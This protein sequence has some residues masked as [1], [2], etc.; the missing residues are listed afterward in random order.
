VKG[1]RGERETIAAAIAAIT[2]IGLGTLGYQ[3]YQAAAPCCGGLSIELSSPV[4]LDPAVR[5]GRLS[6]GMRYFVRANGFP[7]KRAELRLV[8][9]AG[10]VLEDESQRG[11]AHAVEHMAFRGTRNFPKHRITDYLESIGMRSG[12]DVNAQTTFDETTYRLAVPTDRAGALDTGIAILREWAQE[13]TFDPAEAKQEAGVVF[14]EW[15][16]RSVPSDRLAWARDTI[17][18]SGSPYVTRRPIGDTSVLRRFDVAEMRRFYR[19]WYRPDLMAVVAVGDFN[20]ASMESLIRKRFGDLPRGA[21]SAQR[22]KASFPRAA[23]RVAVLRDPEIRATRVAVWYPRQHSAASTVGEYRTALSETLM[24]EVLE[25]RLSS[26][27]DALD[28]PLLHAGI[29]ARGIARGLEAQVV[30]GSVIHGRVADGIAMIAEQVA[31]VQRFGV[32]DAELE[33]AKESVMVSRRGADANG[34]NSADITESLIWHFLH[35]HPFLAADRDYDLTKELLENITVDDVIGAAKRL[36]LDSASIIVTTPSGYRDT[37]LAGAV[38]QSLAG[39][40]RFGADR[41]ARKPVDSATTPK[42]IQRRPAD[43]SIAREDIHRDL[44]VYEWTLG[45]GMRVIVK[46]TEFNPGQLVLRLTEPG[47]AALVSSSQYP[48]AYMADQV[49][50]ATGVGPLNGAALQKLIDETSITLAPFVT[51][52]WIHLDGSAALA[53]LDTLFQLMNLYFTAPRADIAAFTRF[54]ARYRSRT[55]DRSADPDAVFSDTLSIA[56]RSRRDVLEPGTE[57]FA[58]AIDLQS[59]LDFWR[60]RMRNASNFTLVIIGDVTLER[61][62]PLLRTYMASLPAGRRQAP[63]DVPMRGPAGADERSFRRGSDEKARTE[64]VLGG[65]VLLTPEVE[66]TFRALGD[67][68]SLVIE[69]RVREIMGGTYGVTVSLDLPAVARAPYA[70]RIGFSGAPD[71]IDSLSRAALDEVERLRTHGPSADEVA[72][73]KAATMLEHERGQESNSYWLGELA[74]NAQLGWPLDKVR[75]RRAE[76]ASLSASSLREASKKYL[77]VRN[78]LRVT[79][80]PERRGDEVIR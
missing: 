43:G 28:A 12:D 61:L 53:D 19:D 65:T 11:L 37:A 6:N 80:L 52:N 72:K 71:R 3:W 58:A 77:D 75:A 30:H 2:L 56:T 33:R 55:A 26:A 44:N 70:F 64:I 4:P 31:T 54:H 39:A 36:V 22:P 38:S 7:S 24:R 9:N 50:E 51:D 34:S 32:S 41:A 57:R 20:I 15:R 40:A 45:N 63:Q 5:T 17:L 69:S 23:A 21:T 14:E 74:W 27:A 76:V 49:I 25:D 13:V 16:T 10:S 60:Q 48:S 1:G 35:G 67:L 18:L 78:Y 42:L 62:R 29:A 8:V 68:L 73:V 47:G 46:Q 59:A 66:T 79:M